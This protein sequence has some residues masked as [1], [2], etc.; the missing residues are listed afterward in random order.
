M[1]CD[2]GACMRRAY[3]TR[4][5][6]G[7]CAEHVPE[8]HRVQAADQLARRRAEARRLALEPVPLPPAPV[9]ADSLSREDARIRRCGWCGCQNYD[10]DDCTACAAPA[11]RIDLDR[12][13]S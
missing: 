4:G 7:F 2:Y 12:R 11:D 3:V 1:R 6:W 8:G 5:K 10:R 9:A 13:I